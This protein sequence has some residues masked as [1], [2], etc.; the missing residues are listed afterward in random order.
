MLMSAE[1]KGCVTWFLHFLD[2]PYVRHNCAKFH[3]CKICVKDFREEGP[4]RHPP[5]PWAAPKK[6]ILNRVKKELLN[7]DTG[8]STQ[9]SDLSTRA[10]K[11]NFHKLAPFLFGSVNRSIDLS[12]FPKNLKFADITPEYKKNSRNDKTN[13][14]PVS[15]LPN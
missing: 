9:K 3:H 13:Y 15:I 6:P 2:L 14:G 4:K 7:L 11:E 12:N 1:I 10:I 8:N 5:H